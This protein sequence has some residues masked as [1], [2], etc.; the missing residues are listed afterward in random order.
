[1]STHWKIRQRHRQLTGASSAKF[2]FVLRVMYMSDQLPMSMFV[3]CLP[4]NEQGTPG[5]CIE[6]EICNH[7]RQKFCL[8]FDILNG[9]KKPCSECQMQHR[10]PLSNRAARHNK[11]SDLGFLSRMHCGRLA[12]KQ[13]CCTARSLRHFNAIAINRS[14]SNP[15]DTAS[16]VRR[17]HRLCIATLRQTRDTGS[18]QRKRR[19][20]L[21]KGPS[22][23]ASCDMWQAW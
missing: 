1:M 14:A 13:V 9:S 4:F 15:T 22:H 5:S 21:R 18:A 19:P 3:L 8:F 2:H 23:H 12:L 10:H 20:C 17:R 11:E 16:N 6:M 7:A